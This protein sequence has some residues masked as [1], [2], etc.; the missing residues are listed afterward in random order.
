G[1]LS[2]DIEIVAP[3]PR[4]IFLGEHGSQPRSTPNATL[5]ISIAHDNSY[6]LEIPIVGVSRGRFV[7][8]VEST[9][10]EVI[11]AWPIGQAKTYLTKKLAA[12]A[13]DFN[14]ELGDGMGEARALAEFIELLD[15][16]LNVGTSPQWKD[17]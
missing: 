16:L 8:L 13:G 11:D 17:P 5:I 10:K 12:A 1:V 3:L 7:A 2:H 14:E 15:Q 4:S 9:L 6:R